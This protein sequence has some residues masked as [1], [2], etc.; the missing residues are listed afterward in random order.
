MHVVYTF[1]GMAIYTKAFDFV[2]TL[3]KSNAEAAL[4]PAMHVNRDQSTKI[5][6][7]GP[8]KRISRKIARTCPCS[9]SCALL[10]V[11]SPE[12]GSRISLQDRRSVHGFEEPRTS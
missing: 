8:R 5:L 4:L 6:T 2:T 12:D 7:N 11:E 10:A 3:C 1:S 9:L